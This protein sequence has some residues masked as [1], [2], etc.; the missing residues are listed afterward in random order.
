MLPTEM[1]IADRLPALRESIP[2]FLKKCTENSARSADVSNEASSESRY[3]GF[4]ADCSF[5]SRSSSRKAYLAKTD[6]AL[7]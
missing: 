5:F 3:F 2:G 6:I 7:E 4:V 1:V